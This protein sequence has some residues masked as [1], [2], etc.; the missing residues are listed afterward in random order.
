[1]NDLKTDSAIYHVDSSP[2]IKDE[3]KFEDPSSSNTAR[4][5]INEITVPRI[6]YSKGV[7]ASKQYQQLKTK[8]KD[9]ITCLS[10]R[11]SKKWLDYTPAHMKEIERVA[12]VWPVIQNF[13]P[14]LVSEEEWEKLKT[15]EK[16]V[17]AW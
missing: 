10:R 14:K 6:D 11:E 7:S 9:T 17:I 4:N 1:M 13:Y 8:V 16:K 3:S 15:L 12:S 2:S 5:E